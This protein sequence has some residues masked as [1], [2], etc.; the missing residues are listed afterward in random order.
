MPVAAVTAAKVFVGPV[1]VDQ[2]NAVEFGVT[3]AALEAS[4]F[5][6]GPFVIVHPGLRSFAATVG[7]F[8]DFAAGGTNEVFRGL[9]GSQTVMTVAPDGTTA[10][11]LAAMSQGML[12]LRNPV[13]GQVGQLDTL[14]VE[15][16]DGGSVVAQGVVSLAETTNITG[17]TNGTGAQ[18]GATTSAQ[19]VYAAIHVLS[20]AGTSPTV[21][22]ILESATASSFAGATT[23][24]TGTASGTARTEWLSSALGPITDQWWRVRI[25][26][27]GTV[28]AASVLASIAIA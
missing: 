14:Q 3:V 24:A 16:R 21:Q 2:G 10:G 7:G 28:T 22:G 18:L 20:T 5:G 6:G 13:S 8:D 26:T 27:T 17:A 15:L 23:R 1:R 9:L 11:N 12:H 4:Q 19:R 25:A